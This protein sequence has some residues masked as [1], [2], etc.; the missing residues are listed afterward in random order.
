MIEVRDLVKTYGFRKHAVILD[1]VDLSI[2]QASVFGLLGPNGAGKTTLLRILATTLRPTSGTIRIGDYE[3]PRDVARIRRILGFVRARGY[4]AHWKT[5]G[6][7]LR[8]WRWM[9]GLSGENGKSRVADVVGLLGLGDPDDVDT[10]NLTVDQERRLSLAQALLSDPQV[11]VLD[12]PLTGMT[13]EGQAALSEALLQLRSRGKTILLSSPDLRAVRQACNLVA[14]MEEGRVTHVLET[15]QL[16]DRIGRGRQARVFVELDSPSAAVEVLRSVEG[17]VEVRR[18]PNV[19]IAYVN[20]DIAN[21]AKVKEALDAKG[22]ETRSIREADIT[23][24]DLFRA[25]HGEGG[26]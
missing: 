16:L 9:A 13:P 20:P 14:I 4:F 12:E 5:A 21:A 3:V 10:L 6:E 25:L 17:V 7:Y 24:G 26:V 19:A 11:L 22:I 15:R 23:L 2:P 8:F 18:A 1:D